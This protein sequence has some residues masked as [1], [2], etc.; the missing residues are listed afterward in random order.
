LVFSIQK[1]NSKEEQHFCGQLE[2][3]LETNKSFL[4]KNLAYL[5][6]LEHSKG[7]LIKR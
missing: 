5:T 2:N 6:S 7:K 4:F 1:N 3:L